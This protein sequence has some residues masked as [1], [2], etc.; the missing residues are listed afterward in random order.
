MNE[1]VKKI[2]TK[3]NTLFY[4]VVIG[5]IILGLLIFGLY[6]TNNGSSTKDNTKTSENDTNYDVSK[7]KTVTGEEATELF[8]K[9][10]T[11]FLYIGR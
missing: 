6:F 4:V 3:L 5:F 2:E 8:D 1:D 7:M 11:H 10:G 9:K